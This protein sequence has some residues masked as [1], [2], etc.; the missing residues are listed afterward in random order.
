MIVTLRPPGVGLAYSLSLHDGG[1]LL[2]EQLLREGVWEAY[3]TRLVVDALAPGQVFVD[4]GANIGYYTLLASR[5]VGAAGTVYAF[6]PEARNY[7]LLEANCRAHDEENIRCFDMGLSNSNGEVPLYLSRDNLGDHR[8]FDDNAR[9]MVHVR[10]AR[11]DDVLPRTCTQIDFLKIDTQGAETFVVEGL[12]GRIRSSLGTIRMIVE[13]WP[14][15]LARSGS[16]ARALVELLAE[17]GLAFN[18]I[19]HIEQRLLPATP[20]ELIRAAEE[21]DFKPPSDGFVNLYLTPQ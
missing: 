6:E 5:L 2:S 11:G 12:A 8:L 16:S 19:D 13:F 15:G 17:F 14:S 18:V 1:E 7:A 3:E 20:E 4:V 21:G 9:D 10:M